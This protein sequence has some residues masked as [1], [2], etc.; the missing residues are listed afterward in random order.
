MRNS[1]YPN[2][3]PSQQSISQETR[4][5]CPISKTRP[6]V[7]TA[8]IHPQNN[9]PTPSTSLSGC[10]ARENGG[11]SY[12]SATSFHE[13]PRQKPKRVVANTQGFKDVSEWVSKVE[14]GNPECEDYEYESR[15]G[16]IHLSSGKTLPTTP[17]HLD[18]HKASGLAEGLDLAHKFAGI[19]DELTRTAVESFRSVYV[20]PPRKRSISPCSEQCRKRSRLGP[21]QDLVSAGSSSDSEES[22]IVLV[23]HPAEAAT[24]IWPCPFFVRDRVSYLSCWTRHCLLS[25]EDV[26][27]HLCSIHLEPIHCSVCFET[28]PSVR[29]RDTHMRSQECHYRLPVIF[30]G[31]RDSQV[32]ELERQ[33]IARDRSPGLQARQWVKIWCIVFSCTQLPPSALSFSQQELAVCEFRLFWKRNGEGIIA[34]VFAKQRLRQ[35]KIENEGR[36]L[37]ALYDLVADQ[38]VDRLLLT[39]DSRDT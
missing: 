2:Q 13:S 34:D 26:R 28:F 3:A 36:S 14:P 25:V 16:R 19:V 17:A 6:D 1:S 33:G 27:E 5:C 7:P 4:Q 39:R 31:L 20:S 30:D 38:A 24:R 18:S 10:E 15:S 11:H 23:Q 22:H 9:L 29:L 12:P 32:R 21:C 37:Q 35:Y 8:L